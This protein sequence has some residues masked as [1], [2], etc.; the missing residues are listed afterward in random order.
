M[1]QEREEINL[2]AILTDKET[3]C[4]IVCLRTPFCSQTKKKLF[5]KKVVAT[6][7]LSS[8]SVL[9]PAGS[10]FLFFFVSKTLL[11]SSRKESC[12][13]VSQST[14]SEMLL[15]I[16]KLSFCRIQFCYTPLPSTKNAL[17]K[18]SIFTFCKMIEAW[19]SFLSHQAGSST[20]WRATRAILRDSLKLNLE[21]KRMK[22]DTAITVP[23][24]C[25]VLSKFSF[26]LNFCLQFDLCQWESIFHL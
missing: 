6:T 10:V 2:A 11:Q 9:P 26:V 21:W 1:R 12:L 8:Q 24:I 22:L 17:P 25:L 16:E 3:V 13:A 14:E 19:D 4:I 7:V 18:S 23:Y 20:T 5:R 15:P